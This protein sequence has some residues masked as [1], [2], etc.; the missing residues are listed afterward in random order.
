L[1]FFVT[2]LHQGKK[3]R[4]RNSK[5]NPFPVAEVLE[6]TDRQMPAPKE[7]VDEMTSHPC[8]QNQDKARSD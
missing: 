5:Q 2:F 7:F 6:A 3:V 4:T 1:R 8:G